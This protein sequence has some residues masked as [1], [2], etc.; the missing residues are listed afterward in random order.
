MDLNAIKGFENKPKQRIRSIKI[1]VI[2]RG[3]EVKSTYLFNL[4]RCREGGLS[5]CPNG[6]DMILISMLM[7]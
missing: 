6:I 3:K 2:D 1:R 7:A 4:N 5:M